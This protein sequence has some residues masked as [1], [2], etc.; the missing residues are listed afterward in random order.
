MPEQPSTQSSLFQRLQ[1][2]PFLVRPRRQQEPFEV[3]RIDRDNATEEQLVLLI[4]TISSRPEYWTDGALEDP[5]RYIW[6]IITSD[7]SAFWSVEPRQGFIYLEDIR[8]GHSARVHFA[9]AARPHRDHDRCLLEALHEA[10]ALF[11]IHKFWAFVPDWVPAMRV[12]AKRLGFTEEGYLRDIF[13]RRKNWHGAW[14]V[15]LLD[16]EL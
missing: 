13:R 6:D 14:V 16:H 5:S 15:S 7:R 8:F 1:S 9:R 10:S 12:A 4:D 3:I 2:A 11:R